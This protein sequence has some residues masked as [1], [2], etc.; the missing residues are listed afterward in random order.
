MEQQLQFVQGTMNR[1]GS[2]RIG[3]VGVGRD[4]ARAWA[5]LMIVG[6]ASQVD[7]RLDEGVPVTFEGIGRVTLTGI[8]READEAARRGAVIGVVVETADRDD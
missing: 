7:A 1:V 6:G 5:K 3:I 8:E 2:R 4:G